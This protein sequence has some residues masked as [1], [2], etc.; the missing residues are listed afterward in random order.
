MTCIKD[1]IYSIVTCSSKQLIRYQ[2]FVYTLTICLQSLICVA[3]DVATPALHKENK[4]IMR[5]LD[6]QPLI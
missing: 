5:D 6:V 1:T 4:I 3:I 2:L